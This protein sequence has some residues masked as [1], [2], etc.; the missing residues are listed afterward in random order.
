[1]S[2][3]ALAGFLGLYLLVAFAF[4]F[5]IEYSDPLAFIGVDQP[6][7]RIVARTFGK[8]VSLFAMASII[9]GIIWLVS[10][11]RPRE[12][13]AGY[14]Y[15]ALI[16]WTLLGIVFAYSQYVA[17]TYDREKQIQAELGKKQLAPDQR[18]EMRKSAEAGCI[19]VQRQAEFNRQMGVTDRQIS[20]YCDCYAAYLA[21][22]IEIEELRYYA[23]NGR[24]PESLT[25]KIPGAYQACSGKALR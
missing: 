23:T 10:A 25:R 15:A 18:Q 13:R 17:E 19:K 11:F 3:K 22:V 14:H 21:R 7:V 12:K 16:L 20:I 2:K 9:P 24:M 1:M 8:G 6:L 5:L 4:A